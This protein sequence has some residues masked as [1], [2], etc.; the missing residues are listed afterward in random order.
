MGIREMSRIGRLVV[1]FLAD[2]MVE[3]ARRKAVNIE[4]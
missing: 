2:L 4:M 1:K 3:M